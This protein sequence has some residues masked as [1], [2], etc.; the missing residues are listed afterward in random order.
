MSPASILP[1]PGPLCQDQGATLTCEV[2]NGAELMWI[3]GNLSERINPA[4]GI[5]PSSNPVEVAG[6]QFSI[7]LVSIAPFLRSM[8]SFVSTIMMNNTTMFCV[9][10]NSASF[11]SGSVTLQ[12]HTPSKCK[13]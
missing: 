11:T 2:I 7:S 10:S 5:L 13:L 12:V 6:V 8:I 1:D 9:G 4:F 3:Y